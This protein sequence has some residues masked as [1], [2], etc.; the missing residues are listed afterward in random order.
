M[1]CQGVIE[2][3]V[4]EVNPFIGIGLRQAKELPVQGLC[5]CLFQV[6][7]NKE[8]FVFDR[9]QGT[10]AIGGVATSDPFQSIHRLCRQTDLKDRH[11]I[12]KFLAG[13]P[14]QGQQ[15]RLVLSDLLVTEHALS[16]TLH[17]QPLHS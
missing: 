3:G 1:H 10:I 16:F 15:L 9:G 17:L 4:Q 13:Q 5:G 12:R 11:E 2:H 6:D 7:Q 14:G 8:Q